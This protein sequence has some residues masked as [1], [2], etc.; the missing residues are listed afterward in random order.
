MVDRTPQGYF[1]E[2]ATVTILRKGG[3]AQDVTTLVTNFSESG[4]TRDTD[5]I[6]HFGGAFLTVKKPR[7]EFE[8]SFD[9]DINDTTWAEVMGGSVTSYGSPTTGG[10]AFRV[11]SQGIQLPYKVKIEWVDNEYRESVGSAVG[12]AGAAFKI[13]YYNSYG[14]EFNKDNSADDRLTGTMRFNLAPADLLGS[15]QKAE[16]EVQDI[17]EGSP[18]GSW[19]Y[20]SWEADLDTQFGY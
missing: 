4:G 5:S 20:G 9:V 10:S 15:G 3:T 2:S 16:I 1:A 18:S 14:V 19:F 11:D 7:E 17:V 6:A 8:V 12:S 13:I